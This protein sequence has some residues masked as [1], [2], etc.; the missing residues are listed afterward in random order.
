MIKKLD[1][2]WT[3]S[4]KYGDDLKATV[5]GSVY[6]DLLNNK[7]IDDPYYRD[8]EEKMLDIM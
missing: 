4:C 2:K 3:L 8:N 5:P 7:I 1:G 6:N